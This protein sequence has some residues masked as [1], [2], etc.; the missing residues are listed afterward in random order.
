MCI[1]DEYFW[2]LRLFC[3]VYGVENLTALKTVQAD[4][5]SNYYGFS[6]RGTFCLLHV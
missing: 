4:V 3:G 5:F 6:W 1:F 2:G